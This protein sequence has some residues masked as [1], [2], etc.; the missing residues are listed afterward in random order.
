MFILYS[1]NL[2]IKIYFGFFK[3]F[4]EQLSDATTK[5]AYYWDTSSLIFI[6]TTV[7]SYV[8]NKINKE[9]IF[10]LPIL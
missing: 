5:F 8:V 1:D 9:N 10:P 3:I 7:S 2:R 4:K 6:L